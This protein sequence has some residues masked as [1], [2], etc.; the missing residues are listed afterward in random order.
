[1]CLLW[2]NRWQRRQRLCSN[3]PRSPRPAFKI[4][5]MDQCDS[6]TMDGKGASGTDDDS[7]SWDTDFEDDSG[8]EV[9]LQAGDYEPVGWP[10]QH[11]A[12]PERPAAAL[13]RPLPPV[14]RVQQEDPGEDP[15]W[16]VRV[17]RAEAERL[18]SGARDGSFVVRPSRGEAPF[19][20]SL[21]FGGRPF[22]LRVRRRTDGRLALGSEKPCERSFD[23]LGQL[24]EHHCREPILLTSRG[25]PAGRTTLALP[26]LT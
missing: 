11:S 13:S 3:I 21:R 8:Y 17:E 18:L 12:K 10:P 15:P 24:V 22:H 23:S 1:M 6:G 5:I 9:P 2:S 14:P 19:A 26:P 25:C 7:W 20:L 4:R 16:L